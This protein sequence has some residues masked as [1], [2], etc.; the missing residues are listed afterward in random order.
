VTNTLDHCLTELATETAAE[1]G[2]CATR[3]GL[4]GLNERDHL[5]PRCASVARRIARRWT[6]PPRVST[7]FRFSSP[8]WPRIGRVD[9]ALLLPDTK[10]V[11]VE[12]KCGSGRD[13]LGPCAW[14]ALKLAFALQTGEISAGYLLAATP[15]S[16]WT[17]RSRGTELFESAVVDTLL[18]RERF[19]DWW[20]HWERLGD[21]TPSAV[22]RQ[23]IT[24]TVCRAPFEVDRVSWE[25]RVA[26]LTVDH[27]PQ[28]AWASTLPSSNN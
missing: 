16:D 27:G 24:R 3:D 4:N 7:G 22:P 6:P 13:A 25:T 23:F 8:L 2:R 14:D 21:P 19:I 10:P 15:T 1:L 28:I 20:R 5:Q 26:A 12:L 18:L 17:R 11:A 9:I